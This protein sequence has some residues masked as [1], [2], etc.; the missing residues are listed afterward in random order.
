MPTSEEI[1]RVVG[2]LV[3]LVSMERKPAVPLVPDKGRP[4]INK[5]RHID[6]SHMLWRDEDNDVFAF[7][8]EDVNP[9]VLWP[10]KCSFILETGKV[11]G[12]WNILYNRSI[13][14]SEARGRARIVSPKMIR[15]DQYSITPDGRYLSFV[16]IIS[17]VNGRWVDA[18]FKTTTRQHDSVRNMPVEQ[19][20]WWDKRAQI[21]ISTALRHRY[22]W[23]VSI[24]EPGGT[25]FRFATNAAGV[26]AILEEREKGTNGRR[27]ALRAWVTDHW[28]QSHHDP[29]EEVYV[30]KHLRGGERF[31]WRGY[32]CEWTPSQ[33]DVERNEAF[34]AERKVMGRQAIRPKSGTVPV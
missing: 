4:D 26:R 12:G 8:G 32:E 23:S 17:Y 22:E 16:E 9:S 19:K 30:R 15:T 34:A 1:A 20:Q 3:D 14:P 11:E 18:D 13:S 31:M 25:S 7:A 33:Y 29:E 10:I 27:D 24:G 21:F 28:R 5:L 2:E 6:A